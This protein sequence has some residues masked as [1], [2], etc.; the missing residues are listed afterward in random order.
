MYA[1][2]NFFL[3]LY[4]TRKNDLPVTLW[5]N[6]ALDFADSYIFEKEKKRNQAVVL[7]LAG[8]TVRSFKG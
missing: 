2:I 3:P 8:M 7:V 5:D 4:V 1:F 6:F